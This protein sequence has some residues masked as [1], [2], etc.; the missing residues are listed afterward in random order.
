LVREPSENNSQE[1]PPSKEIPCKSYA[2]L[3]ALSNSTYNKFLI[4]IFAG[5][6]IVLYVV[7]CRF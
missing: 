6:I 5:Q 1:V 3:P 2:G 4:L 7:S